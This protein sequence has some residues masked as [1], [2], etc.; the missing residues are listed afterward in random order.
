[1]RRLNALDDQL[2]DAEIISRVLSGDSRAFEDLMR[3]HNE[4]V[5]RAVR[6]RV[7]NEADVEEV[8]QRAYIAA[9]RALGEFEGR[10]RFSTWLVRIALNETSRVL[11][12]RGPRLVASEEEGQLPG[13]VTGGEDPE[14]AAHFAQM[15]TLLEQAVDRL[16]DALRTAFVLRAVQG[17]STREVARTLGISQVAVRVRVHRARQQVTRRLR[18]VA[19]GAVE[20][21]FR[22][23]APRCD[24]VVSRVLAKIES[25]SAIDS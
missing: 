2:T 7:Q 24:R 21:M 10:A 8:M 16:P 13:Q 22:F 4:R 11:R 23:Y 14:R 20:E 5:Y 17:E 6:S 19:G 3:R 12:P 18:D 1:M 9:F 25:P 15:A